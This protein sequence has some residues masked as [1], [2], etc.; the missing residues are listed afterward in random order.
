M[1]LFSIDYIRIESWNFQCKYIEK[2][3][4]AWYKESLNSNVSLMVG[5]T[6]PLSVGMTSLSLFK[7]KLTCPKKKKNNML[8]PP[9]P[10][11]NCYR[12]GQFWI[13]S[14]TTHKNSHAS[15]LVTSQGRCVTMYIKGIE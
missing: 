12:E 9:S 14:E 7:I 8:W 3:C 5:K 15:Q 13:S 11:A 10:V 2:Y 1:Y 4:E 6:C